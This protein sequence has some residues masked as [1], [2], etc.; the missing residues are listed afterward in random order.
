[1][2]LFPHPLKPVFLRTCIL[3]NLY[4]YEPVSI[5]TGFPSAPRSIKYKGFI[6]SD[7]PLRTAPP[8]YIYSENSK[9]FLSENM[10]KY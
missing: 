6:Y 10:K 4:Y 9:P 1:M 8:L 3:K 5:E 2:N 7:L